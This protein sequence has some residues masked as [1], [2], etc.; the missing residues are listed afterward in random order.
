MVGLLVGGKEEGNRSSSSLGH[1]WDFWHFSDVG[2]WCV[3]N[4]G[5]TMDLLFIHGIKQQCSTPPE[6]KAC[7]ILVSLTIY[8]MFCGPSDWG[9]EAPKYKRP[10]GGLFRHLTT[11]QLTLPW[12]HHTVGR[13]QILSRVGDSLASYLA[14]AI[15]NDCVFSHRAA[16]FWSG[17]FAVLR[18]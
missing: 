2:K 4:R 8:W 1:L 17:R 11:G 16:Y 18:V 14:L 9:E 10:M 5:S 3:N 6:T 13:T 15:H 12:R 7:H